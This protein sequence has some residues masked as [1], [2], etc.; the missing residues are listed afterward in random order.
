[1]RR[2]SLAPLPMAMLLW[3]LPRIAMADANLC[4]NTGREIWATYGEQYYTSKDWIAGWYHILPGQCAK[5]VVGSVC[6]WWANFW[7]NCSSF[8][9]YYADDASGNQWGGWGWETDPQ[10]KWGLWFCTTDNAFDENPYSGDYCPPDRVW[11]FWGQWYYPRPNDDITIT[12][13]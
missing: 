4:N 11:R 2:Y 8:I 3:F 13:H 6:N 1:M 12:F 9:L 7:G 5:P 10:R